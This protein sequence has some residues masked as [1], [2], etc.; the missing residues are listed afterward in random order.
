MLPGI[1]APFLWLS[2]VV[3]ASV[4]E[5]KLLFVFISSYPLAACLKRLPNDRPHYKS[6]FSVTIC[7]FYLVGLFDLWSGVGTL[8][9]DALG[10]Y[11]IIYAVDGFL[12]GHMAISH[13]ER[14][15]IN[16][17]SLV[18]ITGGQMVLIM[19]LHAL[20]WNYHDGHMKPELLTDSQKERA[21]YKLP[22]LLDYAG[23]VFFFPSIFTGPAFDYVDYKRWLDGSIYALPPETPSSSSPAKNASRS[24]KIEVPH[25]TIPATRKAIGGLLWIGLFLQFSKWYN[26]AL[27]LS[28]KYLAYT[29]PYRVWILQLLG[30][31][32]R[33]KYYGVW[34][35]T[36]G[37]CIM[38]GISY[39]GID[40]KTGKAKWD[41]LENVNPLGIELAQNS[42]AYLDNWNKNTNKWLRNYIYL[43]VTP[44]GKRPGF[45]ATLATFL[46]SAFWHGFYPGYYLTFL[47][48]A[49]IQTVAKNFRRHLRPFFLTPDGKS[50]TRWKIYYDV[51]GYVATQLAFCFTTAPFVILGWNDSLKCWAR[52]YFY[53]VV[54]VA[55]SMAFFASSG[56]KM[57]VK[58]LDARIHP[59]V[60]KSVA[61]ETQHPPSLGLPNDPGR[62]IDDAIDEIRA[63]IETR[64]RRG[65]AVTMPAGDGLK[66]AIEQKLG[67]RLEMPAWKVPQVFGSEGQGQGQEKV[68]SDQAR[69]ELENASARGAAEGKK[70]K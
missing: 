45:R 46:T 27:V 43:R 34:S 26:V 60:R 54:G 66:R 57:L 59:H 7:L 16:D 11:A 61:E 48:A 35:L 25:S 53:A 15:R 31:T 65:S 6:I 62:E 18:D 38:A 30:F 55:A 17:P 20:A 69:A 37:A 47:L 9:I 1:D 13:I 36:E 52:V 14:Q 68:L 12:M 21:V 70:V 22:E 10:T 41:H 49:F 4:D 39:N 28:D 50:A 19:K 5:L 24:K 64:Q 8:L 42:R 33:M 29:F 63:E 44:A 2:E 40:E 32:S 56:K 23:Y 3:G 51:A 67:H 58:R